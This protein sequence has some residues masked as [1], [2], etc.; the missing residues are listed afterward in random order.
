MTRQDGDMIRIE[1]VTRHYSDG[2]RPALDDVS[3]EF[4]QGEFVF[5]TG[6]SGAGKSTLLK[7][8]YAAEFPDQG[9]V[10]IHGKSVV[11]LHPSSIPYL[12]RNL[13]VIFQDFKLLSRRSVFDN[14][15]L[16]LEVCGQPRSVIQHKVARILKRVGL[17]GLENRL[18][19]ALSAGEQQ[20]AAIA[21]ALVNEPSI[22]LADEPTGNL[23]EALSNEIIDLLAELARERRSTVIVATHD[24]LSVATRGFR[25]IRVIDGKVV[26]DTAAKGQDEDA[27]L[28]Q[29]SDDWSVERIMPPRSLDDELALRGNVTQPSNMGRDAITEADIAWVTGTDGGAATEDEVGVGT[30][31]PIP[32]V[33][34]PV[35]EVLKPDPAEEPAPPDPDG[36]PDDAEE[37]P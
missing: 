22:V 20:R 8:L 24:N 23:D 33:R 28:D 26:S 30:N 14:I 35:S 31:E 27:S 11:R 7:L 36:V 25:H 34:T 4:K 10:L 29:L 1:N 9:D 5:V 18:P 16:A 15:A 6:P 3:L 37:T 17:E 2:A 12:R 19:G 21:R 13:G 32:D